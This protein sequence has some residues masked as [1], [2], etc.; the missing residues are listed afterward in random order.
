VSLL[1]DIM[2][3]PW[4]AGD[5]TFPEKMREFF[6]GVEKIES[7]L[8]DQ[9][10]LEMV[11]SILCAVSGIRFIVSTKAHP[12]LATVMTTVTNGL[13]DFWHFFILFSIV[14]CGFACHAVVQFGGYAIE[15]KDFKTA[16]MTQWVMMQGSIPEEGLSE[17]PF[18]FIFYVLFFHVVVFFLM[19]NFL[20]AIIVEAFLECKQGAEEDETELSFQAD[21]VATIQAYIVGFRNGWPKR[22]AIV[23][24]M[25]KLNTVRITDSMLADVFPKWSKQ[26][27]ATFFKYYLSYDCCRLKPHWARMKGIS[28]EAQIEEL[29]HRMRKMLAEQRQQNMME[30]KKLLSEHERVPQTTTV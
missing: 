30:I 25:D 14:Y 17:T 9:A 22:M 8:D 6:K 16:F 21:V 3:V 5:V 23:Q 7:V 12:R 4:A 24:E 18:T 11:F 1:G 2:R 10:N 26:S 13:D 15:F 20:L 28:R 19:I 29:E 27:R